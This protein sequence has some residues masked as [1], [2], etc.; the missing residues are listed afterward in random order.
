VA[1]IVATSNLAHWLAQLVAVANRFALLGAQSF[2]FAPELG[3][4]SVF[5][6]PRVDRASRKPRHGHHGKGKVI[7]HLAKLNTPLCH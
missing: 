1:D 7:E 3:G 4:P 6:R 5:N 2:W